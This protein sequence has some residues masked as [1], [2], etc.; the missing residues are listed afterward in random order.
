MRFLL[1][2]LLPLGF[3]STGPILPGDASLD[4]SLVRTGTDSLVV[5]VLQDGQLGLVGTMTFDTRTDGGDVL[6]RKERLVGTGGAE[7]NVDSFALDARTLA[8]TYRVVDGQERTTTGGAFHPN[9]VDIVLAALPLAD[10]YSAE[11]ALETGGADLAP[12]GTV[13]VRGVEQGALPSGE[14]CPTW[15]VEVVTGGRRGLYLI[16]Q[17]SRKLVRYF[18]PSEGLLINRVRGCGGE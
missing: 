9:S 12:T 13:R 10:G 11:L 7:V 14:V 18:S 4:P 1:L 2:A 15:E 6:S 5:M 17:E 16:D 3:L 8:P